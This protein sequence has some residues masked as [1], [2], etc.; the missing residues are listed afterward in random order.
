MTGGL[1][2]ALLISCFGIAGCSAVTRQVELKPIDP[3]AP[4][5]AGGNELST[6][7]AELALGNVGLALEA[8]RMAQRARPSDPAPQAAIGDCYAA[9][10]RFDIAEASYEIALSLAPRDHRLLLGLAS[11]LER[12]G[13][14][15]RAADIRAEAE[16]FQQLAALPAQ[17]MARPVTPSL[18]LPSTALAAGASVGSVTVQL[19]PAR[20]ID[21][22]RAAA[23]R[24]AV[25][26]IGIDD[27][28]SPSSQL[29]SGRPH[30]PEAPPPSPSPQGQA[31]AV[32]SP[33]LERLSREE[34]ALV[35]S[36]KPL[37]APPVRERSSRRGM[38]L[39]PVHAQ[40]QW[41][42]LP[43]STA[44]RVVQV[45][46]AA[47]EKGIAASARRILGSRGWRSVAI[48]TASEV[49]RKSIVLYPR[50]RAALGRSLAAQFGVKARMIPTDRITLLLGH[51]LA[52]TIAGQRRA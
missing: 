23:V 9:M 22:A 46:N 41:I 52:A 30:S 39:Q 26:T 50:S 49:R 18:G 44:H 16:R 8:F 34:I 43:G 31:I 19:P 7:Y 5:R 20:P 17:A 11:I 14:S 38:A 33:R 6:G 24:I 13:N 15:S 12:A 29:R 35:T 21:I 4:L 40:V 27:R 47:G 45:L 2:A 10:G 1:K 36:T 25:P 37:W 48:G 28:L 51:D 32:A 3:A 42:P